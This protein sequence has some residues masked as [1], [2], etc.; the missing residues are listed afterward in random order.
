MQRHLGVLIKG[1]VR[2]IVDRIRHSGSVL[3]VERASGS[4]NCFFASF[5]SSW[6]DKDM[7]SEKLAIPDKFGDGYTRKDMGGRKWGRIR[8]AR[9][10]DYMN[11]LIVW[12]D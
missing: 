5:S 2:C 11:A 10:D 3:T 8:L 6:P 9:R 12:R 1:Q 7:A 4:C